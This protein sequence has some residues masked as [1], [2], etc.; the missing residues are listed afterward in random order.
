MKNYYLYIF[1]LI[2]VFIF[3]SVFID[4]LCKGDNYREFFKST[5]NQS[6]VLLGDSI[7]QNNY[8]VPDKKS[9]EELLLE[10]TNGRTK[11]FAMDDA[12]I[13][14]VY[15]QINNISNE[16]NTRHTTIFLSIGGN[17]ILSTFFENNKNKNDK[18]D[19]ATIFNE[20]KELVYY[21]KEIFPYPTLVLFDLYYP[22]NLKYQQY[23]EIIE[24]WNH[25][26]YDYTKDHHY[27]LF[28]ISHLLTQEE[29]FTS[30]IEPSTIGSK[31]IVDSIFNVY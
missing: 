27:H 2:C 29:D 12:S 17:N 9:V 31:K 16:Q 24:E 1:A 15:G 20:Y 28:K 19:L 14:D 22:P 10:R 3:L 6:F 26:L 7:L 8:Y 23:H 13:Q 25:F 5:S 30:D 21:I 11:C 4:R 18:N